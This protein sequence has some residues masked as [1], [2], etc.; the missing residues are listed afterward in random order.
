MGEMVAASTRKD[1]ELPLPVRRIPTGLAGYGRGLVLGPQ[2]LIMGVLNITPD[3]FSDGGLR[4][5]PSRAIDDGLRMIEEGA[6]I[7]D[8]GGESTR[9]GAEAL[10]AAEEL[11]R[12]LPVVERL[13]QDERA[14]VSIDTY[15]AVVA[16]EAIDA[17]AD[18]VNDISGLQFDAA[19]GGVVAEKGAALVLMHMRGRSREMYREAV[20]E[21]VMGEVVSEL[22]QAIGR[23]V[24]AGVLRESIIV[25]PGIG[26]AKRAEHSFESL[27]RLT[28]LA[29]LDRPVAVGPSRK[30]FLKAALGDVPPSDREWGT[31]AAVT[32][33]VLSGAHI[34][35]A[36][37]VREMAQVVRVADQIRRASAQRPTPSA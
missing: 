26:F 20:Y 14:L 17:G 11:R 6:R 9:P 35:R 19:L 37:A 31:A 22:E 29:R 13:A 12:V 34:V 33:S 3:S 7:L 21:D 27:A 36:H 5:D 25:D 10:P 8:I 23:A 4:L 1:Y 32:A 2:T 15:K 30:S 24:A 28:E 18:I 16:R